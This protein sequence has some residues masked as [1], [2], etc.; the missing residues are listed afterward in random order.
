MPATFWERDAAYRRRIAIILPFVLVAYVVLFLST[1]RF[2]YE[3]IPKFIGWRGELEL[4]PEITVLPEIPSMEAE[5]RPHEKQ[6]RETMALDLAPKAEL[7]SEPTPPVETDVKP[8]VVAAGEKD[9]V[10]RSL[11][12][13]GQRETAY[14][15]QFMLIR[16]VTPVYPPRERLQG[17]EGAVTVEMLVDEFGQVA[18]ANV[19]SR[20][21]P[22]SFAD[23]ALDAVRQFQFQPPTENGQP[24]TIW[25]RLRIKFRITN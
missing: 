19:L 2:R 22:E 11:E 15:D 12:K 25:V 13:P 23:A 10:V 3:D 9:A 14:S 17:I 7:R 1:G 4:L 24:T 8:R 16:A 5:P 21:G 6:V 20:V 18:E